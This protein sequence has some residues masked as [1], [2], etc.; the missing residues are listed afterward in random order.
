MKLKLLG[1]LPASID[2]SLGLSLDQIHAEIQNAVNQLI[3]TAM[4]RAVHSPAV[5]ADTLVKTGKAIYRGFNITVVTAVG[6]IDIRDGVAAG[7][8]VIIDTIPIATAAGTH[9]EPNTGI[10][11]ETGIY[12]DYNGG[13]TGTVIVKYEPT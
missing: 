2:R 4:P 8:G 9:Y 6:T 11:C 1:R 10:I 12:V 5:T 13:A 3:D 7:G